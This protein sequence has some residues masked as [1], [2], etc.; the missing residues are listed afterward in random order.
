M[1]TN[2]AKFWKE[3]QKRYSSLALLAKE[4]LGVPPSSSAVESI[5]GNVFTPERCQLSDKWLK[6][7]MF[8][9]YNSASCVWY[10]NINFL[11]AL[12]LILKYM[13]FT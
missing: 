4:T 3:N 10:L 8:I 9:R 2:P 12:A 5:A 1:E 6:Q 11:K 13:D 7:L